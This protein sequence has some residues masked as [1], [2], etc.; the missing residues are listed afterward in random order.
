MTIREV[1]MKLPE[2][3]E[4]IE[5]REL[6]IKCCFSDKLDT[7]VEQSTWTNNIVAEAFGRYVN[8]STASG[9]FQRLYRAINVS[10]YNV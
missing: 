9:Y 8:I 7:E 5:C 3:F 6:A 10:N 4:G 2:V 1:L